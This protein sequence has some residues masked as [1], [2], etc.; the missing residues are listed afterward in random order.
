MA[1][2]LIA[3]DSPTEATMFRQA[4]ESKNHTVIH[5]TNGAEAVT[6][7]SENNPDAVVLDVIMPQLDGF[8]VCRRLRSDPRFE[9]LPIIMVSTRNQESDRFWGMKQGANE[10]LGK[11]FD[12]DVLVSRVEAMLG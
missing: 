11:P 10:Y 1:T 7:V 3:E 2:I 4:F 6:L 12:V 9:K 8:Q 5:A